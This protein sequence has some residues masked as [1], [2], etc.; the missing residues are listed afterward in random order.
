MFYFTL[1]YKGEDGP[2]VYIDAQTEKVNWLQMQNE[3]VQ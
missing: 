1:S 3:T 2:D